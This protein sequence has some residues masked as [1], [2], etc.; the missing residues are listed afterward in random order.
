MVVTPPGPKT[1]GH[2]KVTRG[3]TCPLERGAHWHSPDGR[4]PAP[5]GSMLFTAGEL[6]E[7]AGLTSKLASVMLVRPPV[8]ALP[9]VESALPPAEPVL[10]LDAPVPAVVLRPHPAP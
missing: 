2:E 9:P 5:F 3:E 6:Q 8:P 1:T 4:P 7:S 10:P